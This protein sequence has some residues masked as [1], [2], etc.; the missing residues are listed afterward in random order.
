MTVVVHGVIRLSANNDPAQWQRRYGDS[1]PKHAQRPIPELH[2]MPAWTYVM[3]TLQSHKHYQ[4]DWGTNAWE[5]SVQ[6]L[7]QL[8]GP[9]SA[10]H[11]IFLGLEQA[12]EQALDRLDP[13]ARHLLYAMEC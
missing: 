8:I 7:R 1:W 6:E 12:Q 11:P 4:L 10:D 9:R 13:A 3:S 5:V 2:F